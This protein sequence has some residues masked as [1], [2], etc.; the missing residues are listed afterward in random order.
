MRLVIIGLLILAAFTGGTAQEYVLA[1]PQAGEGILA[2]LRRY[3][4]PD[5]RSCLQLFL[6]I[7]ADQEG[8]AANRLVLSRRYR[9]PIQK[10]S[11]DG[12][13]I[14]TTLGFSDYQHAKKIQ[15]YNEQVVRAGQK[16]ARYIADRELWV[17]LHLLPQRMQAEQPARKNG[18]WPIFGPDYSEVALRDQRLSGKFFYLISGHGGPD[19]GAI[20]KRGSA[21]LCE[22]EYAYDITLRL[23]KRLLEH[24]ARVYVIV[25]D[26]NDGIRDDALLKSD[27]DEYYYG[28]KA[29][30][31]DNTIRL[32][33]RATLVNSLYRQNGGERIAQTAIILHVDSRSN[34]KRIDIFYYYQKTSKKSKDLAR[35]LYQAIKAKYAA[36]QPGRGYSGH[37]ETRNL[38][39][40]RHLQ[41]A[42][43]YIELGNIRN[44]RDQDR[45]V[46]ANNRQAVANWLCEGILDFFVEE[47]L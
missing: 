4:L 1:Q 23:A 36:N 3:Q 12:K 34:A 28:K 29:I 6:E 22:D 32:R 27:R 18:S 42:T 24:G 19:P 21:F 30:S 45:L 37:V 38:F 9:M 39:M 31:A 5:N 16:S 10:F 20:G 17:P 7:N 35:K 14:R 46:I 2:L 25:Q 11:Y 41:P 26:P 47:V 33:D 43:V 13:S 15:E 8:L 40:L 44:I